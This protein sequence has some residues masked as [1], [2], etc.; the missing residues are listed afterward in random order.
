MLRDR[1]IGL[2]V[3]LSVGSA[4]VGCASGTSFGRMSPVQPLETYEGDY[5]DIIVDTETRPQPTIELTQKD[6]TVRVQFWR[7]AEL[8]FKLNRQ[9]KRSAFWSSPSW[10]QGD[11]VDV[12]WI[13]ITNGREN[14]LR[15]NLSD[16]QG[17]LFYKIEDDIKLRDDMEG[18]L[19]FALTEVANKDR[20]INR[21][22]QTID[23]KNGIDDV[24]ARLL[25]TH[26]RTRDWRV[27]PGETVE[28]WV[29]FYSI[30]PWATRLF[31]SIP[32]EI[33]PGSETGRW[34][35]L[36]Y[37]FPMSFDRAIHEAQPAAVR[38]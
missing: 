31:L 30:K 29:P 17:N 34:Q 26:L 36:D 15:T 1:F 23:I 22:S 16:F 33:A 11:K 27:G 18:N 2:L 3:L 38:Y 35:R 24:R 7:R 4:V 25:E 6:V 9:G 32:L 5:A 21:G 13:T 8:D 20:L 28:G 14:P 19:Y 12:F 37:V 10:K